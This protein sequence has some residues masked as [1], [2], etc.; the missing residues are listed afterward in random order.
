MN[1]AM[2]AENLE[3]AFP[4][5]Q[6]SVRGDGRHFEAILVD[7]IF[8]GKSKLARHRLVYQALGDAVGGDIHA[9]SIKAVA[10]SEQD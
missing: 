5:A 2:I 3:K 10:P 9:L 7:E 1:D 6:V 4:Q 8:Q